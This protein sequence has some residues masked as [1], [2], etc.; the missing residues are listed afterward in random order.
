MII[1]A[2]HPLDRNFSN[3][4]INY[5]FTMSGNAVAAFTQ[6]FTSSVF[7]PPSWSVMSMDDPANSWRRSVSIPGSLGISTNAARMDN[8]IFNA[9]GSRDFMTTQLLDFSSIADAKLTFDRAYAPRSSRRDSL[10]IMVST[11]CGVNFLP[12]GYA[13][14][15]AELA[16]APARTTTFIPSGESQWKSD[17]VDLSAYQGSKIIIRFVSV[18]RFGNV[19]YIDNIKAG[20]ITVSLNNLESENRIAIFPNPADSKIAIQLP[21]EI[22]GEAK[23][24]IIG[25]DGRLL[26]EKVLIKPVDGQQN[27]D[28]SKLPTGNYNLILTDKKKVWQSRFSRK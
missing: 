27:I 3:D 18:S 16:T 5:T 4:S 11:D 17:T 12:V 9:F 25:M 19:L 1:K 22:S 13:K 28:I 21:K 24:K 2:K 23:V 15:F 20:G 14:G 7:P 6:P 26:I 8:F 10:I